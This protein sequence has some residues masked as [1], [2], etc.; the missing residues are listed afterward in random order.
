M[1][2]NQPRKKH[3]CGSAN[4]NYNSNIIY[5]TKY[6]YHMVSFTSFSQITKKSQSVADDTS[7]IRRITG[8]WLAAWMPLRSL[9]MARVIFQFARVLLIVGDA[10]FL[11]PDEDLNGNPAQIIHHDG[12]VTCMKWCFFVF[13]SWGRLYNRP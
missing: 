6:T 11:Q 3:G 13:F 4:Y 12:I 9:V 5:R 10:Q 2:H 1:G 8:F 7:I